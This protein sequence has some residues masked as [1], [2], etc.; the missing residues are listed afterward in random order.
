MVKCFSK[1]F[2]G[3]EDLPPANKSVDGCGLLIDLTGKSR[4]QP[5]ATWILKLLSKCLTEGTLCV[6]GLIHASFV[7]SACSLLCYGDSD[8]HMVGDGW[9]KF[10]IHVFPPYFTYILSEMM[11]IVWQFMFF[12][13]ACFGFVHIIATVTSYELI[14]YQ[15]LIRSIVTIL[16]LD[17]EGLPSFR[18]GYVCFFF[19]YEWSFNSTLWLGPCSMIFLWNYASFLIKL[20]LLLQYNVL[21]EKKMYKKQSKYYFF[22]VFYNVQTLRLRWSSPAETWLMIHRWVFASIHSTLAVQKISS[23]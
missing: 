23:N 15:N 2:S 5:F 11:P 8:L 3:V 10:K 9:W 20:L 22:E 14:P 18:F 4:L 19:S 13:K 12:C 16:N 1:T 6:E 17:K 7:S 21:K